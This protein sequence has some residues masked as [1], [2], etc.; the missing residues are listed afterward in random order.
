[1]KFTQSKSWEEGTFDCGLCG[2]AIA[3]DVRAIGTE[4]SCPHCDGEIIVPGFVKSDDTGSGSKNKPIA[5]H[6]ASERSGDRPAVSSMSLPPPRK[7]GE[8]PTVAALAEENQEL[9][10]YSFPGAASSSVE[11]AAI[12]PAICRG[13]VGIFKSRRIGNRH[14]AFGCPFCAKPIEI[15]LR[16][17]GKQ[18]QCVEC[19][20]TMIAPDL[21]TGEEVQTISG[22]GGIAGSQK[23][24]L[25][26]VKTP[27]LQKA[28]SLRDPL[29]RPLVK[30]ETRHENSPDGIAPVTVATGERSVRHRLNNDREAK[31]ISP[32][33]VEV[34]Q[35]MENQWDTLDGRGEGSGN[36]M[37]RLRFIALIM[38]PV[39]MVLIV[40]MS[41]K[42]SNRME[43]AAV[44]EGSSPGNG[45]DEKTPAQRAISL[46]SEFSLL[47]TVNQRLKYVRHPN[48]SLSRMK[49]YYAA[50]PNNIVFP[51]LDVRSYQDEVIDGIRFARM[52]SIVEPG[53]RQR[54][55]FFELSEGG[56]LL[57]DWESATGYCDTDVMEYSSGTTTGP[58][59]MRVM[60]KPS[61]Y[62]AFEFADADAFDCY[63][64]TDLISSIRIY[65]Y[66][67]SVSANGEALRGLH[68]GERQ[69]QKGFVYCTL[70][71]RASKGADSRGARQVRIDK[72]VK[73]N[74]LLP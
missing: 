7:K 50:V 56:G 58:V 53:K 57:L 62:Y 15:K 49:K 60:V 51:P 74:W 37:S 44:S 27:S 61:D 47:S 71:L 4:V 24:N 14:V 40:V 72:M 46:S 64:I 12:V 31:L 6:S 22:K 5:D 34:G 8:S 11:G 1:L 35:G 13:D 45:F 33:I 66:V 65:G 43:E 70:V 41:L 30:S 21:D 25:P 63:E 10:S 48:A 9:P 28:E 67:E 19:S 59:Q 55:F 16:Q 68:P 23:V 39:S 2:Q 32:D 52:T 38:M 36:W 26:G 42:R 29:S 54:E 20:G 69:E 18:L 73:N 17:Q 3:I